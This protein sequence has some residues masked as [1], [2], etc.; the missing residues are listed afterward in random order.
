MIEPKKYDL[1]LKG[2]EP[3][4]LFESKIYGWY[5]D[6]AKIHAIINGLNTD[7]SFKRNDRINPMYPSEIGVF[8]RYDDWSPTVKETLDIIY[9]A[10]HGAIRS[11]VGTRNGVVPHGAKKMYD[12]IDI[13][14]TERVTDWKIAEI[15]QKI[16]PGELMKYLNSDF[17]GYLAAIIN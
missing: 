1:I 2:L 8:I 17:R 13:I 5:L 11:V 10:A 12:H 14:P 7:M 3:E 9:K 6:S 4:E 15:A 16:N